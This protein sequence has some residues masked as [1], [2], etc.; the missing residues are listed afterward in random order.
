M[1]NEREHIVGQLICFSF[2]SLSPCLSR[3]SSPCH[4]SPSLFAFFCMLIT[5]HFQKV[6][7]LLHLFYLYLQSDQLIAKSW[8]IATAKLVIFGFCLHIIMLT[9]YLL[10]EISSHE[11]VYLHRMYFCLHLIFFIF[12]VFPFAIDH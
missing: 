7:F 2:W 12:A 9:F 11:I 4:C 3:N 6:T 10:A 5:V 1:P 8:N